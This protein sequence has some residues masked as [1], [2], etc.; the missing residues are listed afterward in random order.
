MR[1]LHIRYYI[2]RSTHTDGQ[3]VAYQSHAVEVGLA[4]VGADGSTKFLGVQQR[5]YTHP[6]IE[7][8]VV[9]NYR[10]QGMTIVECCIGFDVAQIPTAVAQMM[11][12]CIGL[13][14]ALVR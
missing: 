8:L 4:Q 7:Q 14:A 12:L 10:S 13:Q 5:I 9:T 6:T 2:Y 3:R 11:Y 1:E